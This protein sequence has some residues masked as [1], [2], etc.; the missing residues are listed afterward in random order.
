MPLLLLFKGLPIVS[1]IGI[2]IGVLIALMSILGGIYYTG[3]TKGK[4]ISKVAIAEYK[5]KV[6]ALNVKLEKADGKTTI[7]YLTR[8]QDRT[9]VIEE[10]VYKNRDVIKYKVPEQ[11]KFS[12]GWVYAYN[13]SIFGLPIDPAQAAVDDAS[14]VTD[15]VGLDT[16]NH[17]NGIA[18][19]NAAQLDELS[20]WVKETKSNAEKVNK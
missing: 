9:K 8:Y 2:A 15:R 4:N 13:Q 19:L 17:N 10:T 3:Y 1:K 14:N 7:K 6:Q 12:Q 20:G 18:L 16:I 11:F 5:G